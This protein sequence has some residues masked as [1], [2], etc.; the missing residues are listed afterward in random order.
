M[1][2]LTEIREIK[3]TAEDSIG[4]ILTELVTLAD[5]TEVEILL[6]TYIVDGIGDHPRGIIVCANIELKI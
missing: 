6:N 2:D 3:A 5:T 4:D 1:T